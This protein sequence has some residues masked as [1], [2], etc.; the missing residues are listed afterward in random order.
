MQ[1]G[2]L[3]HRVTL[4]SPSAPVADGDGGFTQTWTAFATRISAKVEPATA[5]SLERV[6]ANSVQSRASHLVTIRYRTGVT[7]TS[8][9]VFHD[10]S[11]RT[12]SVAG[13][14]DPNERRIRL[15]LACEEIVS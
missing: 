15:V 7:T 13:V 11:D 5:R 9:V 3:R 6:V 10:V 12:F 4:Q 14:V 2:S 8:R 1:A